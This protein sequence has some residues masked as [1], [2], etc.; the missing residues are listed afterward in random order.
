MSSFETYLGLERPVNTDE[1]WGDAYRYG[2]DAIGLAVSE[3]RVA[4]S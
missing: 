4:S 1:T 3:R 2:M